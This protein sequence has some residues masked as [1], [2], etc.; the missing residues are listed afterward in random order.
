MA[1]AG[2]MLDMDGVLL[3]PEPLWHELRRGF[4]AEYGGAWGEDDQRA[5]MGDDSWQW[6]EHIRRRCAVPPAEEA[7][8][9]AAAGLVVAGPSPASAIGAEAPVC[10]D[11]ILESL[12]A[13]TS[14]VV[15]G[16]A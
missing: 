16:F 1:V 9:A 12:G 2:V 15:E 6:A 4:V 3:D 7:I 8:A 11:V 10:A 14:G 13:L 5:V